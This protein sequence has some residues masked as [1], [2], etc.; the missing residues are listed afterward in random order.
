M[1]AKVKDKKPKEVKKYSALKMFGL[2]AIS[3][4]VN[5]LPLLVVVIINW[6]AC[7]KTQKEGVALA[8]AGIFFMSNANS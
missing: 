1:K 5:I 2:Y 4:G 6:E 7:T 8:V 3:F